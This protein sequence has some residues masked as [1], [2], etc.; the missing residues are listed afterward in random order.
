V[1]GAADAE[2]EPSEAQPEPD[3]ESDQALVACREAVEAFND[4][5]ARLFS[6]LRRHV[7]A[8]L[9][10][11]VRTC[12]RNL[13]G[14]AEV[15]DGLT[16]DREGRYDTEILAERLAS[17]SWRGEPRVVLEALIE[18]ELA[19]IRHLLDRDAVRAIEADLG[20]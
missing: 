4:R 16:P 2:E 9:V 11:F 1:H 15:F 3:S 18:E 5:H 10:N 7:G 14:A 19:M 12:Q 6:H 17:E 13:G 8:G 20:V